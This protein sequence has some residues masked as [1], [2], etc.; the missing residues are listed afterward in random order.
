[1]HLGERRRIPAEG[2]AR[3]D[4]RSLADLKIFQEGKTIAG[5][6]VIRRLEKMVGGPEKTRDAGIHEDIQGRRTLGVRELDRGAADGSTPIVFVKR[7]RVT[8]PTGIDLTGWEHGMSRKRWLIHN[9][10]MSSREAPIIVRHPPPVH[11]GKDG[12]GGDVTPRCHG[13]DQAIEQ[14]LH[15]MLRPSV[16]DK[17]SIQ[18]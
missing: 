2:I 12:N 9:P 7:G 4:S 5:S 3:R 15:A 8:D 1:M 18:T 17:D 16:P 14:F 11:S 13:K 10:E 6:S